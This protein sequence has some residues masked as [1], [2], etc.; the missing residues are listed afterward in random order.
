MAI[1]TKTR[2]VSD[3]KTTIE[4]QWGDES[5]VQL[6]LP[7]IIRWINDGQREI[8]ET[9]TSINEKKAVANVVVGQDLYA[10]RNDPSFAGI[11][12][13]N[14]VRYNGI[15]LKAITFQE[16]EKYIVTDS[17]TATGTPTMWYE[18]NNDLRLYPQPDANLTGGLTVYFTTTPTPVTTVGSM[19]DIPDRYFNALIQYVM[20]Q[21]Y[22]MDENFQGAQYKQAQ[23]DK[24]LGQ[25]QHRTNINESTYPTILIEPEDAW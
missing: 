12:L 17:V 24:S 1:E 2:T 15:P 4:R 3:V 13:I 23:F 5:G 9:N 10:L 25:K 8:A 6:S 7:D 22:E 21:A 20:S 19:L 16:A 18:D 14:S 11:A